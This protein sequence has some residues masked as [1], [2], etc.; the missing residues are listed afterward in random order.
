[1]PKKS[2]RRTLDLTVRKIKAANGNKKPFNGF[3][4]LKGEV[5]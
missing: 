5:F 1:M 4:C 3:Y 2:K